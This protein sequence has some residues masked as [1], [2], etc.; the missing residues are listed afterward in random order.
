M[1]VYCFFPDVLPVIL[2]TKVNMSYQE[3]TKSGSFLKDA[4]AYF[5]IELSAD[6]D[7]ETSNEQFMDNPE[8]FPRLNIELLEPMMEVNIGEFD[9]IEEVLLREEETITEEPNLDNAIE[10]NECQQPSIYKDLKNIKPCKSTENALSKTN[11]VF[12][13]EIQNELDNYS[14]IYIKHVSVAYL[15]PKQFFINTLSFEVNKTSY[16]S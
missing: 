16:S 1:S 12:Q 14:E 5:T 2:K 11:K 9:D 8:G 10:M 3:L 7:E 15:H 13:N 6:D 4:L